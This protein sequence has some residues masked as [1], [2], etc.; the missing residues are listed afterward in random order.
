V[1]LTDGPFFV[2]RESERRYIAI[3]FSVRGRDLGGAVAEAK[4]RVARN[5][6]LPRG[7][8]LRWDGQ[9]NE[10]KVAQQKL[11]VITPL[12]L[13]AIFLLLCLAFGHLKDAGLIMVNIPYAAIGELKPVRIGN[14]VMIPG[15]PR[16]VVGSRVLFLSRQ[17]LLLACSAGGNSGT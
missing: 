1:K 17:K 3:K 12:T 10:M 5:V 9:F 13:V 16:V 6:R 7:C 4:D 8:E 15:D 2:Y 14:L 11:L